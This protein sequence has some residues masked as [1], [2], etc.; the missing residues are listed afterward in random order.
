MDVP[1]VHFRAM[2]KD[3]THFRAM[4]KDITLSIVTKRLEFDD[5]S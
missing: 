4:T 3:I 2:T 5:Q 1:L